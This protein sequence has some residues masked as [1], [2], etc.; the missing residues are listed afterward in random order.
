V[1]TGDLG[2]KLNAQTTTANVNVYVVNIMDTR[3][4]KPLGDALGRSPPTG[5]RFVLLGG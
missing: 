4:K 3:P 1:G 2:Q 5:S